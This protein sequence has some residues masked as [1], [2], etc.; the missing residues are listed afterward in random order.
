VD[1]EGTTADRSDDSAAHE[2]AVRL[3]WHQFGDTR[4]LLRIE[5]VSA[6]VSTNR[7][8][9]LHLSDAATLIAKS[10]SYGSYFL[11]VED[12]ERLSQ[13][14]TLLHGTRFGGFLARVWQRNDRVY[15]WYDKQR[16][17]AFY[18]EV[19]RRTQLPRVLDDTQIGNLARE[20]AEFHLACTDIAPRMATASKTI[21]SDA[22]NLLDQLESPFAPR[23]FGLAAEHIGVLWRHTH[24]F[25]E[26]LIDVG[27]DEWPKIPVLIDWN[28]GN[29]S[30]AEQAD[31]TF[32]LFSRWDYDWFRIEPRLLDFYF[33]SRVASTTGDRTK[34]S[35]GPHTLVE[36]TFLRFLRAYDEV[37]AL[38]DHEVAFLPEVYRFFI[39]N[40]VVREGRRFFR[41]DLADEFRRSAV[42]SFL[43]ALD[44]LDLSP[45][46]HR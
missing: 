10:S 39:L 24:R 30:V 5:E 31:G 36:P 40:Y 15:T 3:A 41:A 13:C 11:F 7:V 34:F 6:H 44:R 12:H 9:R 27:Y 1:V 35:Y 46:L 33:L 37:F 23:N 20:V 25:L 38:S 14:A 8:Y 42:R 4:T 21:K 32:E 18:D 45:L 28:L 16:W 26:R 43:P 19:P 17:V 2:Q 29:F 22:I